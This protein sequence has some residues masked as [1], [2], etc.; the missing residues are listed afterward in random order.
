MQT[1]DLVLRARHGRVMLLTLNRP[2]R[3]NALSA[4]LL[5][6]LSAALTDCEA[7]P[8]VGALVLTGAGDK[9]FCAGADLGG[10]GAGLLTAASGRTELAELLL[11]LTRYPKPLVGAAQGHALAGGLGLLLACDLVA[12]RA[13]ALY[14]TPEIQRGLFPMLILT[15]LLRVL[16]R[17]R[18][19]ELALTGQPIDGPTLVAWGGANLAAPAA[20][21]LPWA[22]ERAAVLAAHPGAVLALG[23]RAIYATEALAPAAALIELEAA[24]AA[25]CGTAD[26]A[27]GVA[28]FL[29][30]RPPVW[31]GPR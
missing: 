7:D 5:A 14:G 3:R 10:T 26:A 9:A 16:G 17:R 27:E 21:V 22:L 23:R 11:R 1:D 28:A 2:A 6:A 30:K 25:V 20:A 8:Q 13:D 18:T 12:V 15:V 31:P 4:P 19:L 24:L 29:A